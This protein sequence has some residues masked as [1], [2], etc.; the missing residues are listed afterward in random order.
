MCL[1]QSDALL[2][3]R[4]IHPYIFSE[5]EIAAQLSTASALP[6][7]ESLRPHTFRTLFGLLYTTG[8]R[9]DEAFAL[10]LKDFYSELDLLYI[11]EG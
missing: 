1:S 3:Q 7:P 11:A 6:P 2:P 8:I 9:I 5:Q 10:T 4:F